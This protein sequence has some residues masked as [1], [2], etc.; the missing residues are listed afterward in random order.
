[1][2]KIYNRVINANAIE[3]FARPDVKRLAYI[4]K[5]YKNTPDADLEYIIREEKLENTWAR[6][7]LSIDDAPLKDYEISDFLKKVAIKKE[8][9]KWQEMYQQLNSIGQEGDFNFML[10]FVL[11]L[12]SIIKTTR[13]GDIMKLDKN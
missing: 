12:N 9:R 13:K 11:N 8:Q 10:T 1:M 5:D 3:F 6:I 7:M 2:K 4:I